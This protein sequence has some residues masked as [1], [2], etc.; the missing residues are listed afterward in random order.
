MADEDTTRKRIT[1]TDEK[2]NEASN[3]GQHNLPFHFDKLKSFKKVIKESLEWVRLAVLTFAAGAIII[4]IVYNFFA[5]SE[6]DIPDAVFQKLY[7]FMEVQAAAQVT[8][9]PIE[10]HI[11]EW[12][13]LP[14]TND[15]SS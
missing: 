9:T 5:S 6:K 11:Q 1:Q 7:K 13:H 15:T 10:K 12:I 3:Q 2:E 14:E 8:S 4:G